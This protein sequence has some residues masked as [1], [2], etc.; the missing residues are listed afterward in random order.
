MTDAPDRTLA[1]DFAFALRNVRNL[2][3]KGERFSAYSGNAIQTGEYTKS[4]IEAAD[5]LAQSIELARRFS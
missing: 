1:D 4:E 3:D 5:L 2:D